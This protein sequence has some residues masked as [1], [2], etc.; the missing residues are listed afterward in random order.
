MPAQ[1]SDIETAGQVFLLGAGARSDGMGGCGALLGEATSG[2]F[3][4]AAQALT[5]DLAGTIFSDPRPYFVRGYSHLVLSAAARTE[6]GYIGADYFSR[7]GVDGSA[8]PPEEGSNLILAGRPWRGLSVGFGIK[9]LSTKKANFVPLNE[10]IAK[11]YKTAF[12]LG[13]AYT[14][15]LPQTT[16]K[17]SGP[18]ED[19]TPPHSLDHFRAACPWE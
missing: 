5:N 9:V 12:D 3:N 1:G 17:Q 14:G 6:F 7:Q 15:I 8:F 2:L 10:T 16:L 4:P 19:S 11:T 18:M 13:A